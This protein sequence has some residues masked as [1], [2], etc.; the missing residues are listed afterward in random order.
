VIVLVHAA[1]ATL[2]R[3]RHPN[4]GVLSSPRRFYLDVAGWQWAADNDC[5]QRL[6]ELAY[7]RMLA[8][9]RGLPGCLFVVAPDVVGCWWGTAA[10]FWRWHEDLAGFPIAYVIQDGQPLERVPWDLIRCVFVGGSTAYKLSADA[11][12][13]VRHAKACGLWVHMGRV[14]SRKRVH[15]ARQIGCDSIDGTQFSMFRDRWLPEGLGW[16][17]DHLQERLPCAG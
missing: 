15:Y 17:R 6:D 5:F 10:R 14:N 2:E 16:T 8:A 9:L 1:P 12:R 4:L 3:H 13:I 11:E 7:R